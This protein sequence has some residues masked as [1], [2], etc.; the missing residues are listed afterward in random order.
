MRCCGMIRRASS[1]AAG[2]ALSAN[3]TG[4]VLSVPEEQRTQL[5]A[6]DHAGNFPESEER[7]Q[8]DKTHDADRQE[9]FR[10]PAKERREAL[11]DGVSVP[12]TYEH[13]LY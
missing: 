8:Q 5:V 3:Q 10:I 4:V 9:A 6:A 12:N 13:A 11:A 2:E 7:Q 1:E